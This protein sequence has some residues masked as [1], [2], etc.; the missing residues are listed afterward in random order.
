MYLE[1]VKSI[2]IIYELYLRVIC[3]NNVYK[4]VGSFKN[5]LGRNSLDVDTA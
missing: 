1:K 5:A 2:S 4:N 3:S